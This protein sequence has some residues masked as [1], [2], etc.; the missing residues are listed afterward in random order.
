[1]ASTSTNGTAIHS[2]TIPPT[3][4][5]TNNTRPSTPAKVVPPYLVGLT[6][7]FCHI[8]FDPNNPPKDPENPRWENLAANIGNQ[9]LREGEVFFA[10]GRIVGGDMHPDGDPEAPD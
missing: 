3:P 1:M 7:A 2:A 6:C 9:Y 4:S 5:T 8:A 10:K